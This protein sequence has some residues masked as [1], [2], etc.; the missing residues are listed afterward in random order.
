MRGTVSE[1]NRIEPVLNRPRTVTVIPPRTRVLPGMPTPSA[2]PKRVAA[3]ARVSTNSEEQLTS[4]EAQVKHY[5]EYIKCREHTDNWQF[6]EVYTDRG[7][8]GTSTAKREGFNRMMQDALAGKIDLIITKS[9]SRFARNTV[10]TLTAIRRLKEHGV[11]VYFEEQNIYT[12]DG[13]GELLLTIMSSIAQEESRNISENVTWGIRKRFADGKVCMPYKRFMGYRRGE[14]GIPEIVEAEAKIVRGIFRRFLEGA[15]STMIAKELNGAGIPCP[16]R[17]SQLGEEETGTEKDKRKIARWSPSTVESILTNEK[18]KVDA[19]LQKT[20]CTDY[21]QK[22]FVENDGSEIPKYY[23]QNSHPAIISSEVFDLAQM[24]LEWRKS[25]NGSYSGKSCF[26]SRVVC[27]DCGAF[28]GSKVWHSTDKYRRVIWRCNNKYGGDVK[29]STPHVTQEELEKAFVSVMQKV[30]TEKDAIFAVCREVLDEALDTS[31]LDRIATRLQDQALGIAERV[32]K[33][34]EENA[35]VQ[36]N[37]EKYQQE[38][39][40]LTDAY[41]KNSEKLRR[42]ADQKHDKADRRRKIEVFLQ[43]LEDQEECLNFAPYTFVALIDKVVVRRDGKLNFCF[44]NGM[45]YTK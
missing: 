27:G 26:A 13:K 35:R 15:T 17:K 45:N 24:E 28:Y 11:E 30:I 4:Y 16:A 22:T 32:R 21:I 29:C 36:M 44:R 6:V 42:I 10:D 20:Y 25:L 3:Y 2:R 43:M 23:A 5:T 41:E 40:A 38:Y 14:K 9:V 39:N 8:T 31:E 18:Y 7:I 34:V 19:I 12:L 37:Q 33:L 1:A